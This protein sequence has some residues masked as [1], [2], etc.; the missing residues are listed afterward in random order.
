MCHTLS[1]FG[2]SDSIHDT[3]TRRFFEGCPPVDSLGSTGSGFARSAFSHVVGFDD[4]SF[5]HEH[6]GDVTV[7][8]AVFSGLRL[9][10]VLCGRVRR[11]GANATR[12]IVRLITTSKFASQLQLVMLQGIALAGF[13]VVDLLD[14]HRRLGLPV[15]A[16]ARREPRLEK[17][18]EVLV[19]RVP[20]GARKWKLIERLGPMEPVAGIFV[21]R[22]GIVLEDAEALIRRLAVNGN[23]PEPL[24]TAHLIA[25]GIATGQSRGRT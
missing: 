3:N 14:L 6:R 13:N 17:I 20:G 9:E 15:L 18:R 10:G 25:G 24:R 1:A 7:V 4:G 19:R 23:I 11:D 5:E 16:V 21:Q 2:W 12:T 22:V 8:G